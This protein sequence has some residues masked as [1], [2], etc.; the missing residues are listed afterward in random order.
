[1]TNEFRSALICGESVPASAA[2]VLVVHNAY[3]L[4]GG[5]DSVMEAEVALLTAHGHSIKLFSRHNDE[6]AQMPKMRA[7]VQT[8]WSG[9]SSQAFEELLQ[10]FKPDVVHVHNTFPLISPS[11]YWVAYRLGV[12]VVQSLHNF[13]LLCPQAMFLRDFKV[14]ED[15]LG[16]IP[17]RG[18]VRGCYRGSKLQSTLLA[19][20]VT[21]HRAVGT[22]ENKVTRYIALNEFCRNKFIEGGVPAHR[23]MI[24]PNFVDFEDPPERVR[25]GFLFVG[26]LSAEKGLDVLVGAAQRLENVNFRVAGVGPKASLLKDV[27]GIK[28]LGG[29][30]MEEIKFEMSQATALILPSICYE[31]FPRTLVEAFGCSLP[32]IASRVGALASLVTEGKTGLLFEPSSVTDLASKI[33]WA[34]QHPGEMAQMGRNARALYETEFTAERNY[35][36]LIAVYQSAISEVKNKS[37]LDC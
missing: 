21:F 35:Q 32:V 23:I 24:K 30:S 6:L 15:C 22:W 31:S 2:R 26:R 20:M 16:K 10:S 25:D 3:Q 12:P 17:W 11:I 36:Q 33:L 4:R 37:R 8:L 27:K 19:S 5:E 1:M 9:K 29:L 18:A 28:E 34:R 13:R 14:C 7:A